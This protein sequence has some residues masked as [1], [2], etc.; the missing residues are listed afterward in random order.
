MVTLRPTDS[1]RIERRDPTMLVRPG[2]MP[3]VSQEFCDSQKES[4]SMKKIIR[5]GVTYW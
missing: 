2:K 3:I 4:F 5:D 1:N